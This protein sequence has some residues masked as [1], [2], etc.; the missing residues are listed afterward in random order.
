M[1]ILKYRKSKTNALRNI[2]F[3]NR[4]ILR[5]LYLIPLFGFVFFTITT[6][7]SLLLS[8]VVY[9][10]FTLL[11]ASRVQIVV[12]TFYVINLMAHYQVLK[13]Y[14]EYKNTLNTRNIICF[15]DLPKLFQ[16]ILSELK[17][18]LNISKDIYILKELNDFYAYNYKNK[19]VV[20][21]PFLSLNVF[22]KEHLRFILKHE[23]LHYKQWDTSFDVLFEKSYRLHLSLKELL[24]LKNL[25]VINPLYW[26]IRLSLFVLQKGYNLR[27]RLAEEAIDNILI[28]EEKNIYINAITRTYLAEELL[29]RIES[30]N[31][32]D[33]STIKY[34]MQQ[35]LINDKE[36]IE[37]IKIHGGRFENLKLDTE[38]NWE[39][40]CIKDENIKLLFEEYELLCFLSIFNKLDDEREELSENLTLQS[41]QGVITNN[42]HPVLNRLNYLFKD[43]FWDLMELQES[44]FQRERA[45][46]SDQNIVDDQELRICVYEISS[47]N[48]NH[49]T[50]IDEIDKLGQEA[51]QKLRQRQICYCF[52]VLDSLDGIP[53]DII[54]DRTKKYYPSTIRL[55]FGYLTNE[56][57]FGVKCGG[58]VPI[59]VSKDKHE[60]EYRTP[61]WALYR[62]LKLSNLKKTW[63]KSALVD[64]DTFYLDLIVHDLPDVIYESKNGKW[65]IKR[66]ALIRFPIFMIVWFFVLQWATEGSG[67]DEIMTNI[68]GIFF[69]MGGALL[70]FHYP[71][72]LNSI[73]GLYTRGHMSNTFESEE[74]AKTYKKYQ[75]ELASVSKNICVIMM[76]IGI[77][78]AYIHFPRII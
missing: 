58:I 49:Q 24:E 74:E 69:L 44:V 39:L 67:Y 55:L 13:S 8:F 71:L 21:I 16:D 6:L 70:L 4:F 62:Q 48:N 5:V 63:E 25:S 22:E 11:E 34:L 47:E 10:V 54:L 41:S 73:A 77:I 15:D 45:W 29:E 36:T 76:L 30:E 17:E 1:Q 27:G 52:F 37:S 50:I 23:L 26:V 7:I 31:I 78:I 60:F 19:L 35:V 3:K 61:V 38:I 75:L 2:T 18:E 68:G 28:K 57:P 64:F 14:I 32:E 72:I 40:S 51:R 59:F 12:L 66:K 20:S 53:L 46:I 65:W 33:D 43:N 56:F 42:L 9:E